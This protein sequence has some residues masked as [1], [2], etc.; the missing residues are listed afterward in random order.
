MKNRLIAFAFTVMVA[1]SF[2]SCIDPEQTQEAIFQRDK[3]AIE[4]YIMINPFISAVKEYGLVNDAIYIFWE[5]SVSEEVNS[6]MLAGDT[7]T[8]NYTG[9]LLDDTIFDSTDEQIARDNGVFNGNRSYEP[10]RFANGFGIFLSGFEFGISKM[11]AGEK[12]TIIFPSSL[13]YA[14]DPPQNIPPN[15]PLIFEI[16]LLS[17][18]NGPNHD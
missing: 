3:E 13:G 7:V 12:A 10:L 4:N 2:T 16:E 8:I 15:S 14:G 1:L 5:T 11:R 9:R 17:V 18:K 6:S